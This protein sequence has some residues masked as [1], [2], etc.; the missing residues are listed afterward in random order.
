MAQ[1]VKFI[2]LNQDE[3]YAKELRAQIR[4]AENVKIVAEVDEP[5]LLLQ[6]VG[7]FRVEAV[8]VNLDPNPDRLFPVLSELIAAMPD[9]AVFALSASTDGPLILKTIRLGVR[10]FFPKPIDTDAL[11]EAISKITA[12]RTD[13]SK[14]GKLITVTGAAGG[15][16][17]SVLATNLATEL[18]AL[19]DGQVTI[20][21]LDYRF[22]Q[23]ATLL[24][25][26]PTY[27]LADLCNSPEELEAQV[28]ERALVKHQSGLQVLS[29]PA[30]LAQADT[31]TA[32][33]CLGLLTNLVYFNDYVITDGPS[34]DDVSASAVLDIAD[35]NLLVV[36][37]QVPVVRNAARMIE[38]LRES[39]HDMQYTKLI[40]NRVGRDAMML[41]V[42]DVAETL[43]LSVD[44]SIPDD[45]P[46][47]CG[48]INLGE[49]L[50]MQSPKS[51]VRQ[52][53]Q[54]I[55]ERLHGADSASDEQDAPKKGLIGRIF[56]NS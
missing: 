35:V 31:I 24:D 6:A 33:S 42:K 48:A 38:G 28:I 45:W 15:V 3:G 19:S 14:A 53:I 54:E 7:Q 12:Q 9:L 23:V 37:L 51:K 34:R 11:A 47:V 27:T 55:A 30:S 1:D 10:E 52:S 40:C 49:T 36:Q 21:D 4:N 29:R 22:G 20:V 39:G 17:A 8:L 5:A 16:G 50:M 32:A 43:G 44:A 13:E 41:S 26:E 46:A 2:V 18:A 25:V 56:A